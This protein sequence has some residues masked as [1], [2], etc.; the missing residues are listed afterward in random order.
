MEIQLV[1]H[2]TLR[3]TY[4][5]RTLLVDPML[6]RAGELPATPDTPNQRPNPLVDLPVTAERVIAGIDA[7]LVTHTHR[8]H[9]DQAAA[10][11]LPK[12][13]P[14]FCQP[15][16][17]DRLA[18][19]GFSNVTPV[20]DES[21]WEGMRLVRTGGRHGTGDIGAKMGPVSGFVL[22]AEGEP[23]LYLAGDTIWCEEVERAAAV[24]RPEVAVV[25]AGAAQFVTGDPITMTAEDVVRLAAAC[26]SARIVVAHMEAWNHCLLSRAELRAHLRERKLDGRV[27]VPEDG[28][29]IRF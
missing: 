9:F 11:A 19:C 10:E 3:V 4:A 5:N 15:Q 22:R 18:A 17:R 21:V 29:A 1:R 26:P 25:F 7:V 2:A 23:C 8:D 6:S 24:H 16:D 13:I 12:E 20:A 14:V 28:E 27:L